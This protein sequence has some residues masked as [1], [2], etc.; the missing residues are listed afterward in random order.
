MVQGWCKDGAR[1]ELECSQ[2]GALVN[3]LNPWQLQSRRGGNAKFTQPY[4]DGL[5][6]DHHDQDDPA[7]DHDDDQVVRDD[8]L[9]GDWPIK[10]TL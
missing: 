6:D 1:M 8:K 2:D 5:L 10:Y 7:D 9:A 3:T 4:G